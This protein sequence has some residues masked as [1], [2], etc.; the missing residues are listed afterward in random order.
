MGRMP[1][2]VERGK[3]DRRLGEPSELGW[4]EIRALAE[5]RMDFLILLLL[6]RDVRT[7]FWRYY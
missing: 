5:F 1:R 7:N 3:K 2:L 6:G 4:K